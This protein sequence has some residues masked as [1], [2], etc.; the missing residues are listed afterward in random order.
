[1]NQVKKKEVEWQKKKHKLFLSPYKLVS[2]IGKKK[3]KT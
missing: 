3:E 2:N 1:M